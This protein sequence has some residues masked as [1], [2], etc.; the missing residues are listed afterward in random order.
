MHGLAHFIQIYGYLGLFGIT[1]LESSFFFPLPGDSLLFTAGLL[2]TKQYLNIYI[3]IPLFFIATLSGAILGYWIGDNIH[4]LNR[5]KWFRKLVSEK[6]LKKVHEFFEKYGKT[7]ILFARFVPIVRTFAPIGA[8]IG[9]MK[10]SDF[11]K[12]NIVGAALWS[13][14]MTLAGFY[15]GKTFPEIHNYLSVIV[16]LVVLVSVLPGLLHL[17]KRKV[18]KV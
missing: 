10:Y 4:Q 11:I 15:L 8:G 5:Y 3:L 17:R 1:F 2:A 6:N 12:Y 14:S 16:I 18:K 9:A 13:G 7:A